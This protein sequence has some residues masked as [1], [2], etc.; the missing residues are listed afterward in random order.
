MPAIAGKDAAAKRV[1]WLCIENHGGISRG[2]IEGT[3]DALVFPPTQYIA[4]GQTITYRVRW[5]RI[6]TWHLSATGLGRRA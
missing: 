1:E 4:E 6:G 3:D 5:T 2:T